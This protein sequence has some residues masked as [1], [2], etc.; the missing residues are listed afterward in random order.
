MALSLELKYPGIPKAIIC[1]KKLLNADDLSILKDYYDYIIDERKDISGWLHKLYLDEYTPFQHTLFLDSD[2]LVVRD[3]IPWISRFSNSSFTY[4]GIN[5]EEGKLWEGPYVKKILSNIG[6]KSLP[7]LRG[8]GHYYFNKDTPL[9]NVARKV[10]KPDVYRKLIGNYLFT[11]ETAVMVAASLEN[12]NID[13]SS[14]VF[15]VTMDPFIRKNKVVLNCF[16]SEFRNNFKWFAL[17]CDL[18]K[19]SLPR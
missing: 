2:M 7:L 12:Y 1:N 19:T 9:L 17:F 8:G 11:D 6:R 13:T 16:F 14:D 4:W 10:A 3:I 18:A 15:V 5:I